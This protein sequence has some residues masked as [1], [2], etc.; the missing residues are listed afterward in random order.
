MAVARAPLIASSHST[1]P[2]EWVLRLKP[3]CQWLRKSAEN[4]LKYQ[5][6]DRMFGA[7]AGWIRYVV[8]G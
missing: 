6:S 3:E 5:L 2:E 8:V 7:G 4:G 1:V